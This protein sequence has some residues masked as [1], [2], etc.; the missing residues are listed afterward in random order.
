LGC[1]HV[2]HIYDLSFPNANDINDHERS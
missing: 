2:F 1:G